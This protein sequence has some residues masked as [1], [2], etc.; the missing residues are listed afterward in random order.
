LTPHWV[1]CCILQGAGLPEDARVSGGQL[2]ARQVRLW[3]APAESDQRLSGDKAICYDFLNVCLQPR[4]GP[5]EGQWCA[6]WNIQYC[7]T[8]I[9]L[10]VFFWDYPGK[11]VPER[12]NQSGFYWSKTRWGG[13]VAE[14]LAC[15]TQAQ[16]GLGSDRS[17]DA[18]GSWANCSH[19]L[20][21]CSPSNEIGSSPL[22]GC[23]GNCGPGRK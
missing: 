15:W 1:A 19:P 8:H 12:Q 11:P 22:K 18:V 17:R 23:N 13:S 21:L 2:R 16:M 5:H 14:W 10:T 3:P 7:I 6:N 9:R 20:C 4:D